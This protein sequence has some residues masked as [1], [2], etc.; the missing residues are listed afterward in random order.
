ML[1]TPMSPFPSSLLSPDAPPGHPSFW[2][3]RCTELGLWLVNTLN[4]GLW[5]VRPQCTSWSP[6]TSH[7]SITQLVLNDKSLTTLRTWHCACGSIDQWE[8]RITELDQWE[9]T[10]WSQHH[11]PSGRELLISE[12]RREEKEKWGAGKGWSLEVIPVFICVHFLTGTNGDKWA[13][14]QINSSLW[15]KNVKLK[16]K[17]NAKIAFGQS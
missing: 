7:A 11:Y 6:L 10:H 4:T 2:L 15:L 12:T 13:D 9:A 14:F 16:S 5:L 1:M 3:V 8:A 17:S